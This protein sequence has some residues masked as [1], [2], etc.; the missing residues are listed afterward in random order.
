MQLSPENG[1]VAGTVEHC[2]NLVG[3]QLP[4]ADQG[5]DEMPLVP[6][7]HIV[8]AEAVVGAAGYATIGQVMDKNGSRI[9]GCRG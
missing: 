6:L 4:G 3:C 2:L 1:H 5:Q 9:A 7:A 8:T